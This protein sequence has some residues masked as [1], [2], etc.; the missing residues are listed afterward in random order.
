[1]NRFLSACELVEIVSICYIDHTLAA[2]LLVA[3][4]QKTAFQDSRTVPRFDSAKLPGR[5]QYLRLRV[6]QQ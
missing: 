3:I 6:I 5:D 4:L 1:M 2:P